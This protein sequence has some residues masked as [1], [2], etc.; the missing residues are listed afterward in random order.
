MTVIEVSICC[1]VRSFIKIG[2]CVWPPDTLN[3]TMFN[4]PLLGNGRCHGNHIMADMS[5]AWWHATT[6]FSSVGR[7]VMACPRCIVCAADARSVCDS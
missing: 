1:G 7:R 5:E 3:C 6:D 2:S 4:V